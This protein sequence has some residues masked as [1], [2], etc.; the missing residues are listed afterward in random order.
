[1]TLIPTEGFP[2]SGMTL[3]ASGTADVGGIEKPG[4]NPPIKFARTFFTVSTMYVGMSF[5]G[6]KWAVNTTPSAVSAMSRFPARRLPRTLSKSCPDRMLI[7]LLGS[8]IENENALLWNVSFRT[9]ERSEIT[10]SQWL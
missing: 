9:R 7:S 5:S 8:S 10:A 4:D 3:S 2:G 6:G 1:M